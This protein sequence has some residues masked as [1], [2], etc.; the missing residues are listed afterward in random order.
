VCL[1]EMLPTDSDIQ[2]TICGHNFHGRCIVRLLT[3][4]NESACP[5]CRRELLQKKI[6]TPSGSMTIEVISRTINKEI[7]FTKSKK[8]EQRILFHLPP[9]KESHGKHS[10][11]GMCIMIHLPCDQV[12]S[13]GLVKRLKYAFEHGLLFHLTL[14][15][16]YDNADSTTIG[17]H[18]LSIKPSMV[19]LNLITKCTQSI[20]RSLFEKHNGDKIIM[21]I[22]Q[23]YDDD[24]INECHDILTSMNIPQTA[25]AWWIP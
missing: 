22:Y 16:R 8:Y 20:A 2:Q 7:F 13:E 4:H 17:N 19:L 25:D 9:S 3:F 12:N 15:N 6:L 1:D 10:Y 5:M 21:I 24:L 11:A 23:L 18:E 14:S